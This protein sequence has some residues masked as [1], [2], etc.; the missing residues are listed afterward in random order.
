MYTL[1]KVTPTID[2]HDFNVIGVHGRP[3][4]YFAY[5]HEKEAVAAAELSRCYRQGEVGRPC[6]Q[7]AKLQELIPKKTA[8]ILR[9]FF[10]YEPKTGAS[11]QSAPQAADRG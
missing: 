2:G 5:S 1:S 7:I 10:T 4:V 8:A 6:R 9:C 3:L 11:H